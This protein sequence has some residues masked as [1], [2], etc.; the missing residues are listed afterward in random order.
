MSN[1]YDAANQFSTRPADESYGDL[2][3]FLAAL[4]DQKQRS[5]ERT[6]AARDLRADPATDG[7]VLLTSPRGSARLTH[8]A[9]SQTAR[10]ISAPAG[11]LRTLPPDIT[12]AAINYGISTL[13]TGT[14]LV[15]LAKQ[16][17]TPG[18]ALAAAYS[19]DA[20]TPEPIPQIPIIRAVTSTTYGRV[21]DADLYHDVI[22]R[23]APHG[24]DLPPVWPQ[25]DK[26]GTGKAGAYA[27]DRDSF[28]ILANG[29]SLVTDP[30]A[31]RSSS[32]DGSSDSQ[33]NGP[34]ALYRAIIV[35]NSEVGASSITLEQI[36]YR[37]I[38]G[39]HIIWNAQTLSKFRRR[40]VGQHAHRD[41]V[42]E[43]ARIA[44]SLRTQSAREDEQIVRM[45]IDRE[46][47]TTREGVIDAL[48][49]AGMTE[50]DAE[51]AYDATETQESRTTASPRSYWGIV[52]GITWTAQN[53]QHED[54]RF[55][56][57]QIA[58]AILQKGRQLVAA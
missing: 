12:A 53:T 17:P 56:L 21:W 19:P 44:V 46:I 57:D 47:A 33:G 39:N 31:R 26:H 23:T 11:Y 22:E 45:L 20:A 25:L 3:T 55:T 1:R 15:V 29:G 14:D 40:H 16:P 2:Y 50:R 7:S 48:R 58:G 54:E 6:Y 43:I 36:L 38:C 18:A 10:T 28:L 13:P 52:Q 42:R 8:W 37:V 51:A 30:S 24:F 49:A 4:R 41:A 27:S 5:R 35:R 32:L 34:G 9:F